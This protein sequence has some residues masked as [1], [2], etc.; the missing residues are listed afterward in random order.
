MLW[1]W[2]ENKA[3]GA[4]YGWMAGYKESTFQE[5]EKQMEGFKDNQPEFSN[6]NAK[7]M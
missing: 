3:E 6:K 1:T 5:E 4:S 2:V 7:S